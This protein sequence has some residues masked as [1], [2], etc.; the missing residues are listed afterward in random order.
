MAKITLIKNKASALTYHSI[1]STGTV[2][3]GNV[4]ANSGF[5]I[6]GTLLGNISAQQ[7]TDSPI[8]VGPD[9]KVEGIIQGARIIIAGTVIGDIYCSGLLELLPGAH[10]LGDIQYKSISIGLNAKVSGSM[11]Q[12]G[13]SEDRASE[14]IMINLEEM[15]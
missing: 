5:R 2:L 15:A 3:E 6:D 1:I 12:L 14:S 4:Q 7:H 8:A 9:G 11:S 13:L 10:I